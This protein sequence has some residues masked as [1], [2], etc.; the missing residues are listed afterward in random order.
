MAVDWTNEIPKMLF[1]Q[2][3]SDFAIVVGGCRIPCHKLVLR[4]ASSVF[5]AMFA[6]HMQES[7]TNE[8]LV[9]DFPQ[10][11]VKLFLKCVYDKTAIQEE[12]ARAS[13]TTTATY[14]EQI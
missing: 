6:N 5:R 12:I 2:E 1:D 14:C 11:V 9:H 13:L 7:S 8:L 4:I 3:S 10:D